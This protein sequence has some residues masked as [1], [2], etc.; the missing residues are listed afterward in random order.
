M[1]IR[2]SFSDMKKRGDSY[3]VIRGIMGSFSVW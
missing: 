2:F 3:Y 1:F